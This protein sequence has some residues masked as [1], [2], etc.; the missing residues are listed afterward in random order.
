MY[1]RGDASGIQADHLA[2]IIDVLGYLDIAVA[3]RNLDFPGYTLHPLKGNLRGYWSVKISGNWRIIFRVKEGDVWDVGL[4][5][6][7]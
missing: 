1:E 6:Y 7:H 4:V 5:D 3:P 2:R